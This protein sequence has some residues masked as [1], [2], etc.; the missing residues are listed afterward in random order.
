MILKW[1]KQNTKKVSIVCYDSCKKEEDMKLKELSQ[2]GGQW[3]GM[4]TGPELNPE[5]EKRH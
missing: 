5:P 1:K 4:T 3:R 2:T